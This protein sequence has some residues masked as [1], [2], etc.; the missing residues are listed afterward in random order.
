VVVGVSDKD[1]DAG[2]EVSQDNH[3]QEQGHEPEY[4]L[5]TRLRNMSHASD[6]HDV[7]YRL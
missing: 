4:S 3:K 6:A 2:T 1:P 7:L 5:E